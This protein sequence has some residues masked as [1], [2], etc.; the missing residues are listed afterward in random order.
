MKK[1][2]KGFTLVELLAIIA[3]ITI[4]IIIIAPKIMQIFKNAQR[5]TFM[6]QV[7]GM[8][9][10][11]NLEVLDETGITFDCNKY[12]DDQKYKDCTGT[13]DD[14]IS[15]S[16][17]GDGEYSNLLAVD[18]TEDPK[19]GTIIDLS[20][21]NEIKIPKQDIINE[22][23]IKENGLN[24]FYHV[25]S[26]QEII[27]G[28]TTIVG[29]DFFDQVPEENKDKVQQEMELVKT[30]IDQMKNN[31]TIKDNKIMQK[32]LIKLTFEGETKET[33]Q[34]IWVF[35]L[36]FTNKMLGT[37][38]V[39]NS[40]F[41]MGMMITESE[42][43][44]LYN[45]KDDG[46][47]N[48]RPSIVQPG[49]EFTIENPEKVYLVI[50]TIYGEKYE[51]LTIEREASKNGLQL[52]GG[53][54]VDI[55]INDVKN[56]VD[57]GI[58]N[59]EEKLT[60]EGEFYSYTNLREKEGEFVYNYVV[61]T[62]KEIKILKRTINVYDDTPASCFAFAYNN[63]TGE[64]AITDYYDTEDDSP[65]ADSCPSKVYIP[66][67]YNGKDITYISSGAFG[68]KNIISVRLPINLLAIN[69]YA[70]EG[71]QLSYVELPSKLKYMSYNV[72]AYN[73]IRYI[74]YSGKNKFC[75]ESINS[76]R[77]NIYSGRYIGGTSGNFLEYC[78][79]KEI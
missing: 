17:L 16:A 18:V 53:S 47:T 66:D 38:K 46:P 32:E 58:K 24:S 5:E 69:S 50:G 49:Y 71:N 67:K 64:Y 54:A 31:Y 51:G 28:V 63:S 3:I 42:L 57:A 15:I 52:I 75:N 77:Y 79:N 70:F 22:S 2:K 7:R 62:D 73:N 9:K 78:R 40:G 10:S 19:S 48:Y 26:G 4:L 34:N 14:G 29:N 1:S 55:H 27:D 8:V 68:Y 61:K 35:E 60:N 76:Q 13:L 56:Y 30:V 21:L 44:Q 72:F 20:E 65:D 12:L 37:Y 33:K 6:S 25:M 59:N 45:R 11:S 39:T 36:N 41:E 23:L 43:R 74:K